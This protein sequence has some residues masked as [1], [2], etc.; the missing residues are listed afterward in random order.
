ME[1]SLK[2]TDEKDKSYGLAGLAVSL[3]I[4]DSD[5]YLSSLSLDDEVPVN[6]VPGFYFVSNP[7]F[8]AK[9]VWSHLVKQY[10]LFI[11]MTVG[12]YLCRQLVYKGKN[13]D[14][15]AKTELRKSVYEEGK[16]V[17]SLEDDEIESYFTREYS[18]MQKV[19]SHPGV[20]QVVRNFAEKLEESRTLSHDDIVSILRALQMM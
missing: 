2:Y 16:N 17:C 4:Y 15:F 9:E 19:F 7:D 13:V 3:F 8:S 1:I 20:Q 11:A 10:E 12:N 5:E 18:N 14:P 6:F